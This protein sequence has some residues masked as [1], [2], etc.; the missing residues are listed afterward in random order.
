MKTM[1]KVIVKDEKEMSEF[2]K[3]VLTGLMLT[4]ERLIEFKNQKN[5]PL[6]ISKD[7]KIVWIPASEL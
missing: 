4:R 2:A 7:G 6:V 3:K 1:E 5:T